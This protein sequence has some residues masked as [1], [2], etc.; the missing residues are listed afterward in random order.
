MQRVEAITGMR[1]VAALLVVGFHAVLVLYLAQITLALDGQGTFAD[2][3]AFHDPWSTWL[4]GGGWVGVDFFFVLSGF[5]L[6]GPLLAAARRLPDWPSYRLYAAKRLLRIAPPYYAS[7]LL[8]WLL[9]GWS[10]HA[11]YD[12]TPKGLLLHALYLHTFFQ[13]HQFAINGVYWTLGVELQFYLL[14]PLLVIPFRRR[15]W[16][17]A[18]GA[19]ALA[20]GYLAGAYQLDDP[21][22][23]R[24]L[25]FQLPAFLGHFGCGIL[26]AH[27]AR[28]GWRSRVPP[29]V[30]VLAAVLV[31]LVAPAAALG[32]TRQFEPIDT[33][34]VSSSFYHLFLRPAAAVAFAAILLAALQPGSRVGRALAWRPIQWAGEVSYSLYL[35]HLPLAG[36]LL[37]L[38]PAGLV[39]LG[40]PAFIFVLM[41]TSMLLASLFYLA[42]EQPSLRLKERVAAR[43]VPAPE[44][45]ALA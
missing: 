15:P 3:R 35:V 37:V 38:D 30:L 18:A 34:P 33:D 9:V 17:A 40:V 12:A 43:L 8:G 27:L 44:R 7:F 32:Y 45:A 11:A 23:T 2:A 39:A 21:L 13:D 5:L 31:L 6:G 42:V 29:D 26:A 19:L 16:L 28:R 25:T 24:F 14:L 36:V 41:A 1:G 22:A 4:F 20:V 10:H